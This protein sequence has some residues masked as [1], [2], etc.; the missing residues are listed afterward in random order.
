MLY[1]ISTYKQ[2]SSHIKNITLLDEL[3]VV[4]PRENSGFVTLKK[5]KIQCENVRWC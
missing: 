3:P 2:V 5:E 4:Q 1:T